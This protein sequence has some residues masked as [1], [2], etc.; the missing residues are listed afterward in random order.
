MIETKS[1]G[2]KKA[3]LTD[4]EKKMKKGIDYTVHK[5]I[6]YTAQF[7]DNRQHNS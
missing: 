3:F 1:Q 2:Q 4:K 5:I 7:K 6:D